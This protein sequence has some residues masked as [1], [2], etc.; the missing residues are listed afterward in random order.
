MENKKYCPG[1]RL[2]EIK[3]SPPAS[4]TRDKMAIRQDNSWKKYNNK[5]KLEQTSN[6]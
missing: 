2:P 1:E 6:Y 3:N 4:E 5:I